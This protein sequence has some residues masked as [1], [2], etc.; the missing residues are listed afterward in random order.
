MEKVHDPEWKCSRMSVSGWSV[1]FVVVY[2]SGGL[3]SVHRLRNKSCNNLFCLVFVNEVSKTEREKKTTTTSESIGAFVV[4]PLPCQV[5]F[6]NQKKKPLSS[7]K[8]GRCDELVTCRGGGGGARG[9]AAIDLAG[10]PTGLMGPVSR[11][12]R[13]GYHTV[14]GVR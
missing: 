4:P 6:K 2:P 7:L 1:L 5:I 13:T 3:Q 14:G 8:S 9:H 10:A 12:H 11:L